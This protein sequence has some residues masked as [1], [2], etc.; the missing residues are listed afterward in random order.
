MFERKRLYDEAAEAGQGAARKAPTAALAAGPPSPTPVR[1]AIAIARSRGLFRTVF[2][3]RSR[4]ARLI[5][6]P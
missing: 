2:N 4:L 6:A 1:E 5:L 3:F